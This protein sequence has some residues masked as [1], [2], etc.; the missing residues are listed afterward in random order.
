MIRGPVFPQMRDS[1]WSLV[2]S[3]LESIETGLTLVLGSLDCSDGELGPVEGLA[4]DSAGGVVLVM[5]AVEGD[6][7]LSA[8]A[9]SAGRFLE[10]VND[11]LAL[12]I[13][14]ANFCPGVAGR[15]LLIGTEPSATAVREVCALPIAG[16]HACTLEPFRIAGRERFAV[17]WIALPQAPATSKVSAPPADVAMQATERVDLAEI[18]ARPLPQPE[19]VVPPA[20]VGLWEAV[21]SICERIDNAVMV[22]GD[23]FSRTISWSGNVLGGVRT[24]GGAL[25]A[26]AATGVVRDLRDLRDVRRFGD[27]LLRAFVQCAQLD[28]GNDL[29]SDQEHN[30]GR[31]AASKAGNDRTAATRHAVGDRTDAPSGESL[32]SSLA[33]SKLTPEE[34]SALGEPASVAGPIIEGSLAKDRSLDN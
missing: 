30:H 24:V 1:L 8:R 15:I 5:L 29:D 7:L 33:E 27:Q 4:R 12:A 17:R 10:R 3:R 20:R 18:A 34:Y 26:S 25:V 2:S 28:I 11:A 16:L 13:P 14:E 9:L 6:A 23:R 21:L 22:H 31:T 19:F 32:R